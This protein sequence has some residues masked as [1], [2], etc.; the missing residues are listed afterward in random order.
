MKCVFCGNELI[1]DKQT[2]ERRIKSHLIYIKNIPVDLCASCG[3]VYIDDDIVTEMNKVLAL[4]KFNESLEATVIDY[5]SFKEQSA[6]T[7]V[8]TPIVQNFNNLIT[9]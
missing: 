2:I 3:E 5:S 8:G 7:L 6:T 4:I 9:T 1:K